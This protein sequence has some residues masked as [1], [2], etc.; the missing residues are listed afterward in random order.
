M[1]YDHRAVE[2]AARLSDVKAK[3]NRAD[4]IASAANAPGDVLKSGIAA[5]AIGLSRL[6]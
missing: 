2:R 6:P 3:A 4:P 1:L 5:A